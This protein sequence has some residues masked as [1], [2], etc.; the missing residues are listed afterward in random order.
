MTIRGSTQ[1]SHACTPS[2]RRLYKEAVTPSTPS[3]L[4][5][6]D[7]LDPRVGAVLHR[8]VSSTLRRTTTEL[9]SNVFH[10]SI[11]LEPWGEGGGWGWGGGGGG[12]S[13][14]ARYLNRAQAPSFACYGARQSRL[15]R[16]IADRPL[17]RC[18]QRHA[19]ACTSAGRQRPRP[20]PPIT[21][22]SCDSNRRGPTTPW[23]SRGI[24]YRSWT[25]QTSTADPASPKR[26]GSSDRTIRPPINTSLAS[27]RKNARST[28]NT[29]F[30][31]FRQAIRLDLDQSTMSRTP[32]NRL[33]AA[34]PRPRSERPSGVL[35]L[36]SECTTSRCILVVLF[37]RIAADRRGRDRGRDAGT[38]RMPKGAYFRSQDRA[39]AT[40]PERLHGLSS[41]ARRLPH[42]RVAPRPLGNRRLQRPRLA[43]STRRSGSI[44]ARQNAVASLLSAFFGMPQSRNPSH[45]MT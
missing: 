16:V 8:A 29:R 23:Y 20:I 19:A 3:R 26:S 15:E 10:R 31:D 45:S 34:S 36:L 33:G 1:A 24:A 30:A 28:A 40:S 12:G 11:R 42:H 5:G 13:R 22:R 25:R 38:L 9:L 32:W 39:H 7:P 17:C 2:G 37:C 44:Q 18:S 27:L 21:M 4:T 6:G 35:D 41:R 43:I 14:S